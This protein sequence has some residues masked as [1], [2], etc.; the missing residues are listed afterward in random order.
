MKHTG[1]SSSEVLKKQS[2]GVGNGIN[3]SYTP[4]YFKIIFGNIFNL[5]NIVLTP[6]LI[7]LV[8]F[9]LYTETLA[10]VVFLFINTVVS[11]LDQIRAKKTLDKLKQQFQKTVCV[12]RDGKENIIPASEIVIDDLIKARDGDAVMADGEIVEENYLQ[13][14]ESMLTGESNYIRKNSGEKLLSGSFIVTGECLYR[15]EKVGKGNFLNK[16]GSEALKLKERKSNIQK[17]ADKII[18][19]L[20]FSAIAFSGLNAYYA[21]TGGAENASIL[22][23][24]TTII[25]LIIP[26]TL[27]FIFTLTFTISTIKLYRTGVLVQ[28]SGSIEDLANINTICLDKTGTITTNDMVV[29]DYVGFNLTLKELTNFYAPITNLIIGKNKTSSSILDFIIKKSHTKEVKEY[30]QKIY[31]IPF[32][33]KTKFS[34]VYRAAQNQSIFLGAPNVLFDCIEHQILDEITNQVNHFEENGFRVV[35]L[36]KFDKLNLNREEFENIDEISKIGLSTNQVGIFAIEETLNEGIKEVLD[37]IRKQNIQIKII[38]GDSTKAVTRILGKIGI[39]A[40]EVADLSLV[41]NEQE[42]ESLALIKTVFTRA[43]PEDKLK[44]IGALQN[45]GKKVAMVGDGINDVLALKKA[46]VSIAMESGASIARDVADMVL[47]KNDYSKVPKI[48]FEGENIIFNLKLVTKMF[49]AKSFFAILF[50]I[51]FS[52]AGK[53]LP[54]S[55]TS[56]LIF[57]FLGSSAPGYLIVF[58]RKSVKENGRFFKEVLFSSIP[59]AISIFIC[60]SLFYLFIESRGSNYTETNT[61]LVILLASISI[62]YAIYLIA[63]AGKLNSIFFAIFIYL[64]TIIIAGYQ[65]IMPLEESDSLLSKIIV[66]ALMFLGT[67]IIL[68]TFRNILLTSKFLKKIA[69]IFLSIIW[70]PVVLV[71]PFRDYYSVTR[72]SFDIYILSSI[73][74]VVTMIVL[75]LGKNFFGRFFT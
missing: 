18:T 21:S 40:N 27:I 65:T 46:D 61:S 25:A 42:L 74:T 34:G 47:L 1:L 32:T 5:I 4:S 51:L 39:N 72:I 67:A 3:D 49:L 28:K 57:S 10:F 7:G 9:G 19:F 23:S 56:T 50:T 71:F 63:V 44:I 22:L 15:V 14:D 58:T 16:L 54:L 17:D 62:G 13:I 35:L 38:S 52:L 11:I 2:L 55:P 75:Y 41:T 24:V 59:A 8:Y 37:D 31:Q 60:A 43:K 66:I 36:C 73:V 69:L 26:Q 33:S 48:F 70:I 68:Y 30:E 29:K 20:V 53:V 64:L 12:I 45:H 6:L